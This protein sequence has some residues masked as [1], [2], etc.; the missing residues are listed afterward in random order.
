MLAESILKNFIEN[1]DRSS[2]FFVS[3]NQS[4]VKLT[5]AYVVCSRRLM[6]LDELLE[7]GKGTVHNGSY[8]SDDEWTTLHI[9]DNLKPEVENR[10]MNK[11]WYQNVLP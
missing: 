8:L 11:L 3:Q 1:L 6:T 9:P 10:I 5:V 2:L 4:M 7:S